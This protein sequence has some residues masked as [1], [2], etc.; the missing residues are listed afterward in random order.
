MLRAS[1][2]KLPF[3]ARFHTAGPGTKK[4]PLCS[5]ERLNVR[6]EADVCWIAMRLDASR[7]AASVGSEAS[8]FG[9]IP[10]GKSRHENKMPLLRFEALSV[11]L[12]ADVQFILI[13]LDI[14]RNS[15]MLRVSALKLLILGKILFGDETR[16]EKKGHL[17]G[18]RG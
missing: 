12:A 16:R 3:L 15:E 9:K 17:A 7:T 14:S 4:G 10:L 6:S 8:I 2:L 18:S 11:Y 5:F 1:A 13:Y